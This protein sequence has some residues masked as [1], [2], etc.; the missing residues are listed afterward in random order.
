M[1]WY[2]L[3][4]LI[5]D[6]TTEAVYRPHRARVARV[7]ELPATPTVVDLACGTGQNFPELSKR[8]GLDG[9]I[10][11]VD[12]S[13]GMLARAAKRVR[14]G[15]YANVDLVHADAREFS[16]E[17]PVDAIV[18][19][20]GFSALPDWETVMARAWD[21]LAPGGQLVIFDVYAE[22]RVPQTWWTE[23]IARADLSRRVWEPLEARATGF[24]L[25]FLPGSPHL[26]GGRL[27]LAAGSKPR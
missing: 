12:A 25:E 22:R 16:P 2:D 27:F 8:V 20:L 17:G 10:V 1:T 13:A 3:F 5:Y 26:H 19:T 21:Q 24:E 4:A 15:G 11:G 23:L 14:K 18:C 7:L 6:P 9:R